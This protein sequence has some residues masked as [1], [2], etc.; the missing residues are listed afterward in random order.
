MLE[1]NHLAR[2]KRYLW[3]QAP[4]LHGLRALRLENLLQVDKTGLEFKEIFRFNNFLFK[5]GDIVRK[6]SGYTAKAEFDKEG[7]SGA[8]GHTHRL[9]VYYT[10]KRSG[11]YVWLECGCLCTLRPEWIR[12]VPDWQHGLG[13]ISFGDDGHFEAKAVPII[14]YQILWGDTRIRG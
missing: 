11:K 4:E 13:L 6:H 8:S 14:N 7:V 2:L 1:S 9:G 12:G 3:S 5:H 10:T